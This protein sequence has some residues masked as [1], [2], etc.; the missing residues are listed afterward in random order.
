MLCPLMFVL[1]VVVEKMRT[2][3]WRWP[4]TAR[5]WATTPSRLL[6]WAISSSR[7]QFM[8]IQVNFRSL[9]VLVSLPT[10]LGCQFLS[11]G[12][13]RHSFYF[14]FQLIYHLSYFSFSWRRIEVGCEDGCPAGGPDLDDRHCP[15]W[16]ISTKSALHLSSLLLPSSFLFL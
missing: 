16:R 3:H 14:N 11:V 5:S 9:H 10:S 2:A 15:H 13:V 7:R 12:F 1:N 8:S 4:C 6:L